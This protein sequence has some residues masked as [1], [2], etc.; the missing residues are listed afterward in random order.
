MSPTDALTV[1]ELERSAALR[2]LYA[3]VQ[4]GGAKAEDVF[5]LC[6]PP[7]WSFV[8]RDDDVPD[9]RYELAFDGEPTAGIPS[10]KVSWLAG[11][12]LSQIA[13]AL[14]LS[15]TVFPGC[16]VEMQWEALPN[17]LGESAWC[18][19]KSSNH[20]GEECSRTLPVAICQALIAALIAQSERQESVYVF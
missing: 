14:A 8:D 19:L 3:S 13:T 1:E 6:L 12:P 16:V 10:G 4:D 7:G 11:D 5:R 15:N 2:R 18:R 9:R 20:S 17:E